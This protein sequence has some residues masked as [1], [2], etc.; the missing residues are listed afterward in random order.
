MWGVPGAAGTSLHSFIFMSL[1]SKGAKSFPFVFEVLLERSEPKKKRKSPPYKGFQYLISSSDP[2]R[3]AIPTLQRGSQWHG[4]LTLG[5]KLQRKEKGMKKWA[6]HGHAQL[7]GKANTGFDFTQI[8][9]SASK[10]GT[11][12]GIGGG[13]QKCMGWRESRAAVRN[14]GNVRAQILAEGVWDTGGA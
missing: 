14:D 3:N 9:P 2:F 12:T 1:F 11:H 8:L 10:V 4:G 5:S 6:Y 7:F 13:G